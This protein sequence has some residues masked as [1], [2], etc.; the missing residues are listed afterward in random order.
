[1]LAKVDRT[2]LF[3][4]MSDQNIIFSKQFFTQEYLNARIENTVKNDHGKKFFF[5]ELILIKW[6]SDSTSKLTIFFTFKTKQLQL[7]KSD[8]FFYRKWFEIDN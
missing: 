3:I 1:M 4:T 5:L 8:R 2:N 7:S 6:E